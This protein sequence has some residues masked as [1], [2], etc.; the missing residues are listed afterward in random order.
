MVEQKLNLVIQITLVCSKCWGLGTCI[1]CKKQLE[2]TSYILTKK[3][4]GTSC[5]SLKRNVLRAIYKKRD[6]FEHQHMIKKY[7]KC[8]YVWQ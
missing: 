5:S 3:V 8:L 7:R 1:E 6:T 2:L 4:S